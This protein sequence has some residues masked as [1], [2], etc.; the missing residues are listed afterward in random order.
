MKKIYILPAVLLVLLGVNYTVFDFKGLL[1]CNYK[2]Y[3]KIYLSK[4]YDLKEI[5]NKGEKMDYRLAQISLEDEPD[6]SGISQVS[7]L[8]SDLRDYNFDIDS[9]IRTALNSDFDELDVDFHSSYLADR[10]TEIKISMPIAKNSNW[11]IDVIYDDGCLV[12]DWKL[13]RQTKSI[14]ENFQIESE[15]L[16]NASL[17]MHYASFSLIRW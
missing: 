14:L 17:K 10:Q 8:Y 15:G 16:K 7:T 12:P 9:I 3:G 4:S 5:I 11:S 1:N 2:N 6:S 13:N